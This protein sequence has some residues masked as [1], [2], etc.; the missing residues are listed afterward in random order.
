MKCADINL[1]MLNTLGVSKPILNYVI[2][3]H[4]EDS[5]WPLDEGSKVKDKFDEIFNSAKY[6]DCL[7]EIKKVRATHMQ[8]EKMEKKEL[9]YMSADKKEAKQKKK[10]LKDKESA[11]K[12][13]EDDI[14]TID[15]EI[16]PIRKE[17]QAMNEIETNYQGIK[18][19]K[20]SYESA[21]KHRK[22]DMTELIKTIKESKLRVE[23]TFR[24]WKL[25][26]SQL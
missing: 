5:N 14:D 20:A 6:K 8:Q 18:E 7:K 19:E 21:L 25:I 9:E 3:C 16:K 23:R 10:S 17:L 26:Y 12:I 24:A 15:Q 11:K 13:M 22:D 4:Q 1:E 2:F